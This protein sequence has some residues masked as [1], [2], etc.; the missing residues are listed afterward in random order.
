MQQQIITPERRPVRRYNNADLE[1]EKLDCA[2]RIQGRTSFG[3]APSA[4]EFGLPFSDP[5]SI[6]GLIQWQR[7]DAGDVTLNAGNVSAWTD[8]SPAA[9]HDTQGTP[10]SQPLWIASDAAAS[11][12]PG[13]QFDGTNDYTANAIAR[14]APATTST[15]I[16]CV[17]RQDSWTAGDSLF[18]G[19]HA[20]DPTTC[21]LQHATT[22]RL[23]QANATFASENLGAAIGAV[24]R[25]AFYFSGSTNDFIRV[26][27][28]YVTGVSAGNISG[29]TGHRKGANRS[30]TVFSNWTLFD[31]VMISGATPA[32][33]ATHVTNLDSY[34]TPL[35]G[36]G[37]VT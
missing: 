21:V 32:E 19:I 18:A 26:G 10:A 9:N 20:T 16:W 4:G 22:P 33:A 30:A 13:I 1:R 15:L 5:L 14:P 36:A 12:K 17:F 8:R 31:W 23:R 28:S 2:Y 25:G 34:G 3:S 35:Y 29:A 11:N 7:P 24:K 6:A 27:S 37:I